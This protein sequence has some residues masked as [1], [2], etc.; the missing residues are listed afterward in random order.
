MV[1]LGCQEIYRYF[2]EPQLLLLRSQERATGSSLS[3]MNLDNILI[4]YLSRIP[5]DIIPSSLIFSGFQYSWIGT[6]N[7]NDLDGQ[8]SIQGENWIL[9]FFTTPRPA[10]R[11]Y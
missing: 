8:G 11:D 3:Q 7:D 4:S 10:L 5:F 2:I 1:S 9:P 6:S